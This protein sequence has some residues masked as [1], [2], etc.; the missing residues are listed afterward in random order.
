MLSRVSRARGEI[1]HYAIARGGGP[2]LNIVGNR[3]QQRAQTIVAGILAFGVD[4][5]CRTMGLK[6]ELR[7]GGLAAA[8]Q[9]ARQAAKLT[10]RC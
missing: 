10:L 3:A 6:S 2:V 4:P 1:R 9:P 7:F 5:R 8:G